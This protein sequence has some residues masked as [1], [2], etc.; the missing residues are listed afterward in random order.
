MHRSKPQASFYHLVGGHEQRVRHRKA[1][2]LCGLEVDDEF[3]FDCLH[4]RQVGRLLALENT[5]S[6]DARLTIRI[7]KTGRVARQ[8]MR[9]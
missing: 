6:V 3:E 8:A 1:E 9:A 7:G 5:A 4:Y 2:R